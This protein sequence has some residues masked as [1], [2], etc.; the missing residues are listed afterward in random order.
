MYADI[1]DENLWC[2]EINLNTI[3]I[4][5]INFINTCFI[6]I[7]KNICKW[8]SK[9]QNIRTVF[10]MILRTMMANEKKIDQVKTVIS[11]QYYTTE[12]LNNRQYQIENWKITVKH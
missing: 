7:N 8:L 6:E 3:V 10:N 1:K 9:R 2:L 5:Y 12:R 11:A 4:E